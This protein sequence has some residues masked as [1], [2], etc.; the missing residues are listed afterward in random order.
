MSLIFIATVTVGSLGSAT[1]QT[2]PLPT[3]DA[4]DTQI[5]SPTQ[6]VA[7]DSDRRAWQGLLD[8]D[9]R[10]TIFSGGAYRDYRVATGNLSASRTLAKDQLS[11]YVD[12]AVWGQQCA[13]WHGDFGVA[14]A[15]R[16]SINRPWKKVNVS[17][18]RD[19]QA[20]DIAVSWDG[21]S[22]IA[23]WGRVTSRSAK[24]YASR[25]DLT[26]ERLDPAVRLGNPLVRRFPVTTDVFA[27]GN[28]FTVAHGKQGDDPD[29]AAATYLQS[30]LD[31]RTWN[32]LVPVRMQTPDGRYRKVVL[33]EL[34]SRSFGA[35]GLATQ[36][37]IGEP[38]EWMLATLNGS[39]VLPVATL[40]PMRR[41][42]LAVVGDRATVVGASPTN[43]DLLAYRTETRVTTTIAAPTLPEGAARIGDFAAIGQTSGP[44]AGFT[45]VAEYYAYDETDER[46]DRL[47]AVSGFNQSPEGGIDVGSFTELTS[48]PSY[49]EGMSPRI[50]GGGRYA[51]VVYGAS[52]EV[53]FGVRTRVG[54]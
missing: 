47:Y 16:E 51:L 49:E 33:T 39:A 6:Q 37:I 5:W 30:T 26:T 52:G 29:R 31:G 21:R 53:R 4:G 15:C 50:A 48:R 1:A 24:I 27:N 25:F 14:V 13:L 8:S 9:G 28:G 23:V 18:E 34:R 40:P 20:L 42:T 35:F 12:A 7:F 3:N 2:Q 22:A 46:A 41:P 43:T 32:N 38:T 19:A 45:V 11:F 44:R 10:G 17:R 36:V 54:P